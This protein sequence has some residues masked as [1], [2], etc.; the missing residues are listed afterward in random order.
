M[1]DQRRRTFELN[2][3]EQD[4]VVLKPEPESLFKFS[5]WGPYPEGL[6]QFGNKKVPYI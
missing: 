6:T 4:A 1:I 2:P 5:R 3:K